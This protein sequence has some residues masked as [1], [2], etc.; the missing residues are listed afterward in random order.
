MKALVLA[1]RA[2]SPYER[3]FKDLGE[4]LEFSKEYPKLLIQ[5]VDDRDAAYRAGAKIE[6]KTA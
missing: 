5:S 3:D 6:A 4:L 1:P 2:S